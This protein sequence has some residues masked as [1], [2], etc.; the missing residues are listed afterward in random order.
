[1]ILNSFSTLAILTKGIIVY[2]D[3]MTQL[4]RYANAIGDIIIL[5]SKQ[6]GQPTLKFFHIMQ[7]FL[8]SIFLEQLEKTGKNARHVKA[9]MKRTKIPTIEALER[10]K[11]TTV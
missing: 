9:N 3:D 10:E 5:T 11:H 6:H 1:M 2:Q 7:R 4:L 8:F